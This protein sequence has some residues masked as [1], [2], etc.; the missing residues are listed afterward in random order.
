MNEETDKKLLRKM[1]KIQ[2][3]LQMMVKEKTKRKIQK[4]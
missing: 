4:K 1:K 3:K 2:I